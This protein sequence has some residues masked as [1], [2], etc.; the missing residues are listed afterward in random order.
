MSVNLWL[1]DYHQERALNVND[2][3]ISKFT[4]P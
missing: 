3:S 1:S 2:W 4:D